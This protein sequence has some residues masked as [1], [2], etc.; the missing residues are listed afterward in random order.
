[1][2]ML[3]NF[4][5]LAARA[6]VFRP[7]NLKIIFQIQVMYSCMMDFDWLLNI[8][9]PKDIPTEASAEVGMPSVYIR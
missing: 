4:L 2:C 5:L 3:I 8:H 1:M 7:L 6:S 9:S